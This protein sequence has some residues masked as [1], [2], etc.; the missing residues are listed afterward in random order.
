MAKKLV[1]PRVHVMVLCDD[2]EPSADEDGVFQLYGVRTRIQVDVFPYSHPQLCAYLQLTGHPGQVR[3]RVVVVDPETDQTMILAE[4]QLV[5]LTGP[6]DVVATVV[7]LEDCEFAAPGLY[8]V[9]A[10]CDEKL[11]CE[12]P[13]LVVREE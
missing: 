10:I 2:F 6:L 7:L 12:R 1:L 11:V 8:Y 13:L 9:Q 5:E 3:C 4:P